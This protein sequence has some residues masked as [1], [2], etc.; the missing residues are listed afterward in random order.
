MIVHECEQNSPQWYAVKVGVPSASSFSDVLAKGEGKTRKAYMHRLA[1]ERLTGEFSETYSNGFIDGGHVVED[2][3]RNAYA[4][5]HDA[6]PTRVGFVTLDD[7]SAG[8][9]PDSLV[10]ETGGLEI[11]SALPNLVVGYIEADRFPAEHK[12]QV[13]GTLWITGREWWDIAIGPRAGKGTEARVPTGI[14]LFVKRAYRDQSYI[15]N[16][17]AEVDRFNFELGQLVE[18]IRRYGAPEPT[19]REQLEG[20]AA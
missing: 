6:S 14:P 19:L 17:A 18:R 11:K 10:G 3:I 4:F 20:S 16:L 9:S 2:E 8:C 5:L 7:G 13:Q 1:A 15:D 12:A